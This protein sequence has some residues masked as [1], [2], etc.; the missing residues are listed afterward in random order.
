MAVEAD[1]KVFGLWFGWECFGFWKCRGVM[2]SVLLGLVVA[3]FLVV[4]KLGLNC[5][6]GW[7]CGSEV[8][9]RSKKSP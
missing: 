4:R 5:W 6:I 8:R 9:L 7:L 1:F 2:Q 3:Y